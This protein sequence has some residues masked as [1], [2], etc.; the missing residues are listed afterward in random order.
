MNYLGFHFGKCNEL[1]GAGVLLSV[2]EVVSD[3]TLFN[4]IQWKLVT[5]QGGCKPE[6]ST[7]SDTKPGRAFCPPLV[8]NELS[9]HH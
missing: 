4:K 2:T 5:K 1:C 3:L 8:N 7:G 6:E 9:V